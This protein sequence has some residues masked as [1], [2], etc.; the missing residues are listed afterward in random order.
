VLWF[1]IEP[2]LYLSYRRPGERPIENAGINKVF[3]RLIEIKVIKKD[4]KDAPK[5]FCQDNIYSLY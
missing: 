4:E 2:I 1:F 5:S 3:I